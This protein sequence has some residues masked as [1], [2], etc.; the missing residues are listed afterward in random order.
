MGRKKVKQKPAPQTPASA[1]SGGTKGGKGPTK[2][3]A[4]TAKAT[5][6]KLK[7]GRPPRSAAVVL[8]ALEG[9]AEGFLAE[10][11]KY[12]RER[13]CLEPFGIQGL[14]PRRALTR[15]IILEVPGD[16][17][18]TKAEALYNA[19]LPLV[20]EKGGRLARPT[21][22]VELRVRD[23]DESISP[24]EIKE[25]VG[26]AGGCRS[27]EVKVGRSRASPGGLSTAWVQCPLTAARK[28]V[29]AGTLRVGWVRAP[30]EVLERRPCS[31]TDV[32]GAGT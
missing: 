5:P 4:G 12:V 24:E 31:A 2:P 26:S 13:V 28:V 6:P 7:L 27:T 25:A 9:A 20:S 23:L 29:E 15:A 16:N 21:K 22:T 10:V 18:D 1:K 30:I 8:S 17:S 14:R 32:S 3:G 19:M 11:L